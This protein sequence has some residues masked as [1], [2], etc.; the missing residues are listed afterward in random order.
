[1]RFQKTT[2]KNFH[3]PLGPF[4]YA[5]SIKKSESRSKAMKAPYHFWVTMNKLLRVIFLSEKTLT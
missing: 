3:V 1:M 5:K 4:Y 2:N